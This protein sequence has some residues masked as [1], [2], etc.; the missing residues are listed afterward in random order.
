MTWS[1]QRPDWPEFSYNVSDF[2]PYEERF[3]VRAGEMLGAIRHVDGDGKDALRVEIIREEAVQSSRIEG[4]FLD[5]ES[6]QSS[7]RRH[8][9]LQ[10]D[11]ATPLLK[12]QGISDLLVDVF[13]SFD[14]PLSHELFRRWHG[15]LFRAQRSDAGSY[16]SHE[17]PMQIVSGALHDPKVHYEAP[18]TSR[19]FAEMDALIAQFVKAHEK[20]SVSPLV[21]A[22][23]SHLWFELIHP[24]EDGN[25]RIGRALAE[26]SLSQSLG[27]PALISL[28]TV[29]ERKK[30]DYYTALAS[31]NRTKDIGAWLGYFVPVVIEAQQLSLRKIDFVIRKGRLLDRCFEQ[32]NE[33]QKKVV[34]RMLR[35][36]P[37]GFE[38]GLSAANFISITQG[39]KAT[40]TRDLQDLVEKGVLSRTGE[41]RHTRYFLDF[42]E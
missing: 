40:V 38:G 39:A 23:I 29:I 36:G 2:T 20:K 10:S 7:I 4:E 28:S 19:V 21:L 12:E 3:L 15:K 1:W 27:R 14:E 9:G 26:K 32:L 22:G 34:L 25:G 8:F 33:R 42:P 24:F 6:I 16:R 5:R 11:R 17:E 30:A 41:K 35:E 37:D 31:A 13:R 18:P